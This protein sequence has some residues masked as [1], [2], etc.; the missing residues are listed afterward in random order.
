MQTTVG[1]LTFNASVILLLA[2]PAPEVCTVDQ[3]RCG[4]SDECIE[5]SK[6]CD[7]ES[8]CQNGAD[9]SRYCGKHRFGLAV[10]QR[11]SRVTK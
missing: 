8:D 9:E 3:F 2:T 5:P 1:F 11:N 4:D 10:P 6:V 7:G